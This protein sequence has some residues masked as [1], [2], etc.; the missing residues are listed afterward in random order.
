MS[1][2]PN[3]SGGAAPIRALGPV[4]RKVLLP[5]LAAA[6]VAVG[7]VAFATWKVHDAQRERQLASESRARSLTRSFAS[8]RRCRASLRISARIRGSASSWP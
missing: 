6:V 4:E 5:V 1:I 3:P 8:P 2:Q 7:V